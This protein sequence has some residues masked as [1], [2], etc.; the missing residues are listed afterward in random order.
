VGCPGILDTSDRLEKFNGGEVF[1]LLRIEAE[2]ARAILDA[3]NAICAEE[4]F[5]HLV[6]EGGGEIGVGGGE[7]AKKAFRKW[8]DSTGIHLEGNENHLGETAFEAG[9]KAGNESGGGGGGG[10]CRSSDTTTAAEWHAEADRVIAKD[11][12]ERKKGYDEWMREADRVIAG[13][14]RGSGGGG[15]SSEAR[16]PRLVAAAERSGYLSGVYSQGQPP[17]ACRAPTSTAATRHWR[18]VRRQ[19]ACR[20]KRGA[21]LVPTPTV[22]SG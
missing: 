14:G 1:L 13:R 3:E 5:S 19:S 15:S 22:A 20:P 18:R 4:N 8:I 17:S 16:D 6:I 12:A 2:T 21:P 9:F 10:G 11:D 7:M